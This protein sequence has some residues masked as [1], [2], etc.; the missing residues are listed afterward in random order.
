LTEVVDMRAIIEGR[1]KDV[2]IAPGDI[3]YVSNRPWALAEDLLDAAIRSFIRGSAA[4]A[5]E[6][7]SSISVG[8]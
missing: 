5:F 2:A 7:Q 4:A 3:V 6:I 8:R 1:T